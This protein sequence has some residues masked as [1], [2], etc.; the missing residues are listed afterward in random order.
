[1][2]TNYHRGFGIVLAAV[3]LTATAGCGSEIA[4]P[5]A[6]VPPVEQPEQS[7]PASPTDKGTHGGGMGRRG[8]M[9]EAWS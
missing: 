1:M 3:A 2:N 5:P 4:S 8:F 6:Y 7:Q 9:P